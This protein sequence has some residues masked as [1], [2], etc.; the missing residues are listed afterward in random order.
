MRYQIRRDPVNGKR[1]RTACL[2]F[3]GAMLAVGGSSAWLIVS[4]SDK[5]DGAP[6]GDIQSLFVCCSVLFVL[7][8][9]VPF[10]FYAHAR[11][12]W[13]YRCPKCGARI[14]TNLNVDEGTPIRHKCDKCRIDWETGWH[15]SGSD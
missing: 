3:A 12:T 7:L 9:V 14:R 1:L 15:V 13:L 10:M 5:P 11:L 2:L 6:A 8:F 4:N